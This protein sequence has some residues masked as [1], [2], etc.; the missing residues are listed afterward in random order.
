MEFLLLISSDKLKGSV[1]VQSII[2]ESCVVISSSIRSFT[3]LRIDGDDLGKVG[4]CRDG[5]PKIGFGAVLTTGVDDSE[6]A[7]RRSGSVAGGAGDERAFVLGEGVKAGSGGNL[8]VV[9]SSS[10]MDG[11]C[12]NRS[13]THEQKKILT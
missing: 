4:E 7:A 8:L 6:S 1:G 5:K 12:C 2:S 11:G 9:V 3:G 10:R 13:T